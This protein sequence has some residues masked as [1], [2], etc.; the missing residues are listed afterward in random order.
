MHICPTSS[1][2]STSTHDDVLQQWN[3]VRNEEGPLVLDLSRVQFIDPYGMV[4]LVL[5]LNHLPPAALP[6]DLRL[7]GWP[8]DGQNE[9]SKDSAKTAAGPVSYLTRMGFWDEVYQKLNARPE[10][11]PLRPAKLIDRNV[12]LDITHFL[13]H[14]TISGMLEQTGDILQNLG[15]TVPARGHVLEVLS[16]LCSNVL[17]HAQTEFGGVAAMQTYR[18]RTGTRYIVIGIGDAGIGVRRSLAGNLALADRLESDAQALGVAAQPGASR[19]AMG[20]HGGGLPRVMEIAR[21][22]AGR[23]AF[24][25]GTGALAFNGSQEERRIFETAPLIGTQLRISLP[26]AKMRADS[27]SNS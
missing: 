10:Q 17:L 4:S 2:Y 3:A 27:E 11:I 19:F 1:T 18:G 25:S 9:P 15:Y 6:V 26:E 23:V 12:L 14:D 21:R 22:Y 5:F 8:N 24:R 20:G 13:S 7:M 16:E